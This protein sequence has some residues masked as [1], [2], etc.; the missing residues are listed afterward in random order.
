[1]IYFSL[2]IGL[3]CMWNEH[4][5]DIWMH[6]C[7]LCLFLMH[8]LHY[9]NFFFCLF[10]L[11]IW[12]VWF[13]WL[14]VFPFLL[15]PGNI[16]REAQKLTEVSV[17]D[18]LEGFRASKEVITFT[19]DCSFYGLC[20]WLLI[21]VVVIAAATSESIYE[22]TWI[23]IVLFQF[24]DPLSKNFYQPCILN[25]LTHDFITNKWQM[26]VYRGIWF[27]PIN[28]LLGKWIFF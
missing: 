24:F 22:K 6:A 1:M 9:I 26:T 27:G 21:M 5:V 17:S 18:K 19:L 13:V 2:Y 12:H 4:N 16:C 23:F 7:T 15:T 11:L 8:V 20:S 3:L 28:S 14:T 10:L 25:W